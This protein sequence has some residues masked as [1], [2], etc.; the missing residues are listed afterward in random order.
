MSVEQAAAAVAAGAKVRN[1]VFINCGVELGGKGVEK[2]SSSFS[3]NG[4]GKGENNGDI[5]TDDDEGTK[6][7]RGCKKGGSGK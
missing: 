5:K 2:A 7:D 6:E 1:T 3:G 4:M